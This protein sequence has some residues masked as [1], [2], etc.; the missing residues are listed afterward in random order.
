MTVKQLDPCAFINLDISYQ[1]INKIVEKIENIS[2]NFIQT[3]NGKDEKG[4][5]TIK[6][7]KKIF[8]EYEK[9]NNKILPIPVLL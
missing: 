6:Y 5:C 7:P 3:I 2:F 4:I 1:Y 8:C 9:R